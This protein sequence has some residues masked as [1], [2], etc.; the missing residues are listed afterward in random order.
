MQ[1]SG[2]TRCVS[3]PASGGASGCTD[4]SAPVVQG[5]FGDSWP[6]PPSGPHS[7]IPSVGSGEVGWDSRP[8]EG[9]GEEGWQ[10]F[11]GGLS[12]PGLS[13]GS[14][15]V[16]EQLSWRLWVR[17]VRGSRTGLPWRRTSNRR[18]PRMAVPAQPGIPG[19]PFAF[20]VPKPR[21]SWLCSGE[22]P[23]VPRRLEMEVPVW[24]T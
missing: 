17:V 16:P 22:G 5:R 7:L 9:G 19:K 1:G 20:A 3:G 4:V 13:G 23:A 11:A 18:R 14:R 24:K 2:D 10:R 15:L 6:P 21:N 8:R 12:L